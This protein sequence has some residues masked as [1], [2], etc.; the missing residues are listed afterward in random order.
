MAEGFCYRLVFSVKIKNDSKDATGNDLTLENKVGTDVLLNDVSC[1]MSLGGITFHRKIYQ[2]GEIEAEVGIESTGTDGS[3]LKVSDISALLLNRNVQ[4]Y[5]VNRDGSGNELGKQLLAT[6]YFV[7]ELNP[8]QVRQPDGKMRLF[9]RLSIFSMDKLMTLDKYSKTYVVKKLG[10]GILGKESHKFGL[11]ATHTVKVNHDCLCNLK[12]QQAVLVPQK[13]KDEEGNEISQNVLV[14]I[15]S[16][17]IQPYLVQYNES[18]YDFLVRT[19][20]RCGEFLYFE[21]GQ[22]VMGLHDKSE[23]LLINRYASVTYQQSSSNQKEVSLYARDS[24]KEGGQQA[25]EVNYQRVVKNAAGFPKDLFPEEAPYHSEL[26]SDEY[27]FPLYADKFTSLSREMGYEDNDGEVATS[28]IF[29]VLA[30]AMSSTDGVEDFTSAIA[31]DKAAKQTE[32]VAKVA[33]ANKSGNEKFISK[34]DKTEFGNGQ[35]SVL[36]GSL[37]AEGW[38]TLRYYEDIHR[39]EEQLQRGI[40]CIDMGTCFEAVKLGQ[41]IRIVEDGDIYIVIQIQMSGE[42]NWSN[43]YDRYESNADITKKKGGLSQKIFAIPLA[44]ISVGGSTVK[45]PFPPVQPVPVVRSAEPQTAF[46][47]ANDDPKYQ[48]RVRIAYPWQSEFKEQ[49]ELA[50][51]ENELALAQQ[52][53]AALKALLAKEEKSLEQ[54]TKELATLK[55]GKDA[56]IKEKEAVVQAVKKQIG[57]LQKSE[58]LKDE[59]LVKLQQYAKAVLAAQTSGMTPELQMVLAKLNETEMTVLQL[60]AAMEQYDAVI[61]Q[62]KAM[63][64]DDYTKYVEAAEK[65]VTDQEAAVEN[66]KKEVEK[67]EK[68][69]DDKKQEVAEKAAIYKK[70]IVE[71]SSPWIRVATPMATDGGG[72]FFKPMVGDEVLVNYEGGNI[73]RPYVVGSLFSKNTLAPDEFINRTT[74]PNLHKEASIAIVSPNGHGITFKDPT[75]AEEFVASV[76]PAF[77]PI[78]NVVNLPL[79]NSKDLMGGIRIGDRFGLYSID[80]SADK[81]SVS[82]SSSMGNVKLDAYTGITIT[83]PNGDVKIEG[84]NVSISAGNNLSLTSGNNIKKKADCATTKKGKLEAKV[85]KAVDKGSDNVAKKLAPPIDVALFRT[86][87][88]TFLKPIEGTM[89]IKSKRY[90]KLEAGPGN[91]IINKSRYKD[92]DATKKEKQA[93]SQ[94]FF[95]MMISRVTLIDARLNDFIMR[96][97]ALWLDAY[98][99]KEAYQKAATPL[100]VKDGVGDIIIKAWDLDPEKPWEGNELKVDVLKDAKLKKIRVEKG[101]I[102]KL[103]S[104]EDRKSDV[105]KPANTLGAAVH[106]LRS[107][108]ESFVTLFDD[109]DD[110]GST[111]IDKSLKETFSSLRY[112]V[113]TEAKAGY[114]T[115]LKGLL[116]AAI[117]DDTFAKTKMVFKRKLAA[118]FVAKVAAHPEHKKDQYLKVNYKPEEVTDEKVADNF[119][120]S[121]FVSVIGSPTASPLLKSLADHIKDNAAK[122]LNLDEWKKIVGDREVWDDRKGGQILFSDDENSTVNFDRGALHVERGANSFNMDRLKQLMTGL[123]E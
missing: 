1:K 48:G 119:V 20:N 84:K 23:P 59:D 104:D 90:L 73:E 54:L 43:D 16:E 67:Q 24:M 7:Y 100:F 107:H 79:P 66:T 12:Y 34:Y 45:V 5:L 17:F 62:L 71:I 114:G 78:K 31:A 99:K 33:S 122:A 38:T 60:M 13:G 44:E 97:R 25:G 74:G 39:Y 32:G 50:T 76:Y 96:H 22:L 117:P 82:I 118:A 80:M 88:E 28:Q 77:G 91:T 41:K 86:V 106:A 94:D 11:D 30:T 51:A 27:F 115:D 89:C 14:N 29:P 26:S 110:V 65:A 4:L 111:Y 55:K 116:K 37:N 70:K 10:S 36:F 72:T 75:N 19:A 8:R 49:Q 61:A 46:V 108:I 6:N 63:G 109:M 112:S 121:N 57:D 3:S 64:K 9:V 40:I 53:L 68:T 113:M 69:V 85:D 2:P 120:W 103:R 35:Q 18:F 93:K 81:R 87:L 42:E 83:A 15:P 21:D 101:T 98:T 95:K 102:I 92:W 123:R 47:T 56:A 105:L 58:K 52:Q